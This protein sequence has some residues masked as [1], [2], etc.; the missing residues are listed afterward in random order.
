MSCRW[1]RFG[2][3]L[4]AVPLVVA[5]LHHASLHAPGSVGR[6]YKNNT[7]RDIDARALFYTE[8]GDV[9][10]FLDKEHGRYGQ[11]NLARANSAHH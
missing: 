8:L 9:S 5:L 4:A 7:R 1:V 6:V 11:P 10:N 2:L 3:A